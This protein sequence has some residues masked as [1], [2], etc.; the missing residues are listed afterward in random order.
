MPHWSAHTRLRIVGLL[1]MAVLNSLLALPA[2]AVVDTSFSC[3]G[4]IESAGFGDIGKHDAV[5]QRAIDCLATHEITRGTSP[6]TFNPSG[7]V[8]RWQMALF[9]VRQAETHGMT[10]PSAIDQG[11]TDL[12]GLSAEAKTAVNQ[13]A[14]LGIT[15]G[16]APSTFS[17]YDNVSRWQMALFI[18]RLLAG[19]G[20]SIPTATDQGFGDLA[21]LSPQAQG[22]INQLAVLGVAKGTSAT[23]FSPSAETLRWQM[24]LFLTRALAVGGVLPPG[25]GLL[26]VAPD[27]HAFLD[28]KGTAVSRNYTVAVSTTG[29]FSI[30]LWPASMIRTNGSF[31]SSTPGS[32]AN[33]DITLVNGSAFSSD[34]VTGI[35]PSGAN[36]SFTVGCTGI[37]GQLVPVVYT[38]TALTGL[39]GASTADAK[40]PTNGA[41]GIGGGITVVVEAA[42][43]AFGPVSVD[44]IDK[45]NKSFKSGG[46]TYFWDAND[47][48][49]IGGLLVTMAEWV[50][51]LTTGDGLL[52]GSTYVADPAGSSIFDLS[53]QSPV[54]PGLSLAAVTSTTA[55]LTYT[56]SPGA[57][58]IKIYS[59]A[60]T[61]CATTLVRTV[62]TGTDE[63]PGTAGTQIVISGL[64]PNTD[65]DFQATQV[66]DSNESDKS[67]AVDV[68]TPVAL[69]IV[70]AY[71]FQD[72]N[73]GVGTWIYLM[74]TFD[75]SIAVSGAAD[76]ADFTIHTP[77]QP[78]AV[79]AATLL[80]SKPV[81]TTDQLLIVFPER[82][83]TTPD[84]DWV[85]TIKAGALNVGGDPNGLLTFAFS[86]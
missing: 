18:T 17:P 34:K 86:H 40:T 28:F 20:V 65:Y 16:T 63:V 48:F 82:N 78:G 14:Q 41:Y 85:L 2:A 36:L 71:V 1:V 81:G 23:T 32:I 60:G 52:A 83:D 79:I 27:S 51:A 10:V 42:T 76:V 43:G 37:Q 8:Q 30:E 64:T 31:E 73:D 72:T 35:E 46:L 69:A 3:P 33:C 75:R 13:L 26:D 21:G 15:F 47:T 22:A 74:V 9:L 25:V 19:S 6:T 67:T 4:S 57:G 62:V 5:T 49:R 24:A 44:S 66:E 38:G 11:F 77:A 68:N 54:A 7:S 59:C 58:H 45:V 84:T 61:G 56:A 12:G 53:D 55:T 29:P 50:A 39:A 80:P 70:N